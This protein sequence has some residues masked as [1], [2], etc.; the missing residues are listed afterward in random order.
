[1]KIQAKWV[2]GASSKPTI[3]SKTS[4]F[5]AADNYLYLVNTASGAVA[6]QL[7]TPVSGLQFTI[8]DVGFNCLTN[9]IT[10]VRAAS[11]KIENVAATY[12]VNSNGISITIVSDGTD[13]YII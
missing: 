5:T 4:A 12:V 6:V 11:E 10:L 2:V 9:N 7:P 1:M 13:F 3:S 8:K